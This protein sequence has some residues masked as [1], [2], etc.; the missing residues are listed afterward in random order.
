MV[1]LRRIAG[2]WSI[3]IQT[4]GPVPYYRNVQNLQ[5]IQAVLLQISFEVMLFIILYWSQKI[6]CTDFAKDVRDGILYGDKT[7]LEVIE[8]GHGFR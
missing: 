8:N 5:H 3:F 6:A 7:N 4:Y 1:K 2:G